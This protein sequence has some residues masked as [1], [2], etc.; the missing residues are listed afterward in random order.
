MADIAVSHPI[1]KGLKSTPL[2]HSHD[3][4][5]GIKKIFRNPHIST[6]PVKSEAHVATNHRQRPVIFRRHSLASL[7]RVSHRHQ[8]CSDD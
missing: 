7:S 1:A 5:D 4:D 8:H 3:P 2:C 6:A